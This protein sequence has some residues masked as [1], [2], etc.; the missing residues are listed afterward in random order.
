MCYLSHIQIA[1]LWLA[2][3]SLPPGRDVTRLKQRKNVFLALAFKILIPWG[4]IKGAHKEKMFGENMTVSRA[5]CLT[6]DF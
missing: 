1:K 4:D 3:C 5:S 6:Q 2:P